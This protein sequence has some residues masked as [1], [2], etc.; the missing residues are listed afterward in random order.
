MPYFEQNPLQNF[1]FMPDDAGAELNLCGIPA[2][3][4]MQ[5]VE[6]LLDEAPADASYLVLFDSAADDGRETLFRPLGQR[7]LRA[8]REGRL[9]RCLPA[10]DGAAYFIVFA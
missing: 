5:T 3:Q 2:M 10:A 1:A 7:L 9:K 4:A 8:R 6:A